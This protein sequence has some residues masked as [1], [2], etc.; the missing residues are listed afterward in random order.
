MSA[1]WSVIDGFR[2][3]SPLKLAKKNLKNQKKSFKIGKKIIDLVGQRD[4]QVDGLN[5][6]G[7]AG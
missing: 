2:R 1:S 7:Q 4:H 6:A 3:A 5:G